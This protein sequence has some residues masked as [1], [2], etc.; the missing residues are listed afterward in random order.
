MGKS[1]TYTNPKLEGRPIPEKGFSGLFAKEA[2]AKGEII[3]VYMGQLINGEAL[4]QLPPTEQVHILQIE[5]D[6]YIAP[7]ESE[8]AH[9]VNHSCDPNVGFNGQVVTIA[10]RDIEAGEE[11]CFD[12]AMCDGSP[13][14][15]FQC[16]CGSEQCRKT[17]RGSDWSIPELWDRYGRYFS[18]YLLNR[19]EK[20]RSK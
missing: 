4:A 13:Y 3:T 18:P 1:Y 15:E 9:L 16:L 8:D 7:Y 5:E 10:L 12:Y 11:I 14:D 2:V 19:I 17:I 20:H 6:L